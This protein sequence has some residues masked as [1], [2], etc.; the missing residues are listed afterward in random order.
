M[1]IMIGARVRGVL[2]L[3]IMK[4]FFLMGF[5][6]ILVSTMVQTWVP[7]QINPAS[8]NYDHQFDSSSHIGIDDKSEVVS[9]NNIH[10]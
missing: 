8:E 5:A 2:N 9:N 10:F 4:G 1:S 6:F 3:N 7:I